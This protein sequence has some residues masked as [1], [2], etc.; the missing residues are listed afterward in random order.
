MFVA[1]LEK[2][3]DIEQFRQCMDNMYDEYDQYISKLAQELNVDLTCALDI[4]YLRT[5]SRW[6]QELENELIRI[7]MKSVNIK[8]KYS[9]PRICKNPINPYKW[10]NLSFRTYL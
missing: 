4:S 6:S 1:Q 2:D 5:R 9:R 10:G 3:G 8:K 7:L